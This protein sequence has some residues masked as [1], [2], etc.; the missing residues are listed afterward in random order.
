MNAKVISVFYGTD[1]L[2]YKDSA[3]TVHYPITGNTFAGS[4]STSAIKFYVDKIG[5][6][7]GITW[8]VV[9][10][11]PNGKQ[12]Y[13]VVNNVETDDE[14]GENYILFSLNSYYT[15]Q[16]G[17]VKLALRGY[18]GNISFDEDETTGVYSIVGDPLIEVT[19]TIDFAINYSPL[20][21]TGSY[22]LPSDVDKIL[23]ALST[24]GEGALYGTSING[25]KTIGTLYEEHEENWF[26]GKY[27]GS[28]LIG[29]I[30]AIGS[31]S[32]DFSYLY[33]SGVRLLLRI[34]NNV[35]A[36]TT[37]ETALNYATSSYSVATLDDLE[38]KVDK[39]TNA[40]GLPYVYGYVD[41][42]QTSFPT[43][44][45]TVK[46]PNALVKRDEHMQIKVP[47]LPTANEDAVSKRYVD[48]VFAA[49]LN[50][51]IDSDYVLTFE[52]VDANGNSI[53]TQTI[54]LPLESVVVGGSYDETT[55]SLVLELENGNTITIPI[56][57]IVDGLVS[58]TDLA[59]ILQD[60][61]KVDGNYPT[62]HVGLAD[63]LYYKGGQGSLQEKPF[64]F[65]ATGTDSNT[66]TVQI[67]NLLS[68]RALRG[69]S[70]VWNQLVQN[71]NFA[72]TSNWINDG[73]TQSSVND[74]TA[75][76]TVTAN[77]YGSG[78]L[79][80]TTNYCVNGHKYLI[81]ATCRA[82]A[83]NVGIRFTQYSYGPGATILSS[84][85]VAIGTNWTQ[86]GVIATATNTGSGSTTWRAAC[87]RNN[88]TS[89]VDDW[90]EIKDLIV[91]DLTQIFG[92]GNEPTTVDE[93]NALFPL[94]Y[95]DYNAGELLSCKT[96]G[97]K[98][99]GYNAYDNSNPN[100]FIR[101]VSGQKYT[102]EGTYTSVELY[103]FDKV[104]LDDA[105][106]S[107]SALPNNCC[108]VKIVGGGNDT[109]LHLTWD[110][111]RTGY[112]EYENN[113]YALPNIELRSAG[114]VY[115]ELKPDGT[116]I[117]RIGVRAY[118]SGDENNSDYLTDKV[119]TLYPLATPTEE[120]TEYVF[121]Q[122]IPIDDFG[123][124]EF[125]YDS[126]IEIP[127]PQG[128]ESYYP[129]NYTALVDQLYRYTDGDV[130]KLLLAS[131]L[132]TKINSHLTSISGYNA[133]KTQT[134]KNVNGTIKWVDD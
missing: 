91:I 66:S 30:V 88:G 7:S 37:L 11:L 14:L 28:L 122:I 97:L 24:A 55:H 120:Q 121:Q 86:F 76:L 72:N 102:L 39:L 42:S 62:M 113:T 57:D 15:Q 103:D 32:Y 58:K 118:E 64:I 3:R 106:V 52:L 38:N 89:V 133:T 124:Q 27:G 48:N 56:S 105:F 46:V 20:G 13:E 131:E 5:G 126:D 67:G 2:P 129:A 85:N 26:S 54:D 100:D 47:L 1:L 50:V 132:T 95:Y 70:V 84:G 49:D 40:T 6:T 9:S 81:R 78:I 119:N 110:G 41:G 134:L 43:D 12:G 77:G 115:D 69:N 71:G 33:T 16:K 96:N 114:S 17:V 53:T 92:A 75:R 80:E 63:D 130:E 79:R 34:A 87:I 99:V 23:A 19:G 83:S 60:Y 108:Y 123:T 73:N 104:L 18:S 51:E 117:R 127:I 98:V 4:N 116:L 109:C 44:Y 82:S 35:S 22:L 94:P 112:E 107:G 65:Q 111:S 128:N 29:R 21:D 61:A 125:L 93:F 8:V 101:V 31:G 36:D 74:N 25:S 68:L 45:K 90:L 59:T 10:K